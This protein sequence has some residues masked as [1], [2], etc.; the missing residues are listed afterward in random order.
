MV[1]NDQLALTYEIQRQ[2]QRDQALRQVD[3]FRKTLQTKDQTREFDL[4]D[5]EHRKKDAPARLSDE[6]P[7]NGPSSLQ[8]LDGE[9]LAFA[10]RKKAQKEQMAQWVREQ[11]EERERKKQLEKEEELA[12]F[13]RSEEANQRGLEMEKEV[14]K[15][16]RDL[17]RATKEYN[18]A[19]ARA[20]REHE[21]EERIKETLDNL[22]EIK[23]ALESDLLNENLETTVNVNDP[24]RFKKYH[25]KG[26]RPDQKEQIVKIQE[27]QREELK[28]RR[29]A[30]KEDEKAWANEQLRQA[31]V[32][33]LMD[34]ER[35]RKR[36]EEVDYLHNEHQTQAEEMKMRTQ[37]LNE[38]YKND[39]ADSFHNKFNTSSR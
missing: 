26:L 23:N 5:P 3:D 30:E 8:R 6:D 4:N 20:K 27:I 29:E 35:Q 37:S 16:K 13:E 25:F 14:N 9:D 18:L 12:A 34:R 31:R 1:K 10:D 7:R 17:E 38:M 39:I 32:A 15:M 36:K 11:T 2:R 19:Q 22:D 24:F 21:Q 33:E 28:L